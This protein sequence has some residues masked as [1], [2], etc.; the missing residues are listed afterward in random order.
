M[1]LL[2]GAMDISYNPKTDSTFLAIV[3]GKEENLVHLQ[4]SFKLDKVHMGMIKN[5]AK[6][7]DIL[8]KTKF[9]GKNSI[10]F[11]IKRTQNIEKIKELIKPDR[12]P[13]VKI[14]HTYHY[15]LLSSIRKH[16]EKFLTENR[17]SLT[18]IYFECDSD[19]RGFIKDVGLHSTPPKK[20]HDLADIVAW[21]NAKNNY[22]PG[23]NRVRSAR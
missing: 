2:I 3:I 10:A 15:Q 16:I 1:E 9:D 22:L 12:I 6:K 17:C 4:K 20:I 7:D 13:A 18:D 8:S 21:S 11:C 23:S 19:C 5:Q 14:Y